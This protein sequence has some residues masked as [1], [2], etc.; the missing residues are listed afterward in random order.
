MFFFFNPF[1]SLKSP[2]IFIAY[3]K[4]L[5]CVPWKKEFFEWHEG[6][7]LNY[8]FNIPCL[9][10]DIY[11]HVYPC[12]CERV[13]RPTGDGSRKREEESRSLSYLVWVWTITSCSSSVMPMSVFSIFQTYILRP[14]CQMSQ[15]LFFILN[16]LDSVGKVFKMFLVFFRGFMCILNSM[17]D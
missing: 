1:W 5:V 7:F 6:E 4:I 14:K 9:G 16:N 8:S 17:Q 11:N 2:F 10:V 12:A 13:C 15:T 3:N